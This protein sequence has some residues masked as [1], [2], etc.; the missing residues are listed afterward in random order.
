MSEKIFLVDSG[1]NISKLEQ[2]IQEFPQT[3]NES[4]FKKTT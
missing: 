2:K 1:T 4:E 3:Q